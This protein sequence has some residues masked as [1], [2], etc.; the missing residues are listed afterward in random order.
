MIGAL[1]TVPS[2]RGNWTQFFL[3]KW[4]AQ[5]TCSCRSATN[6]VRGELAG[7]YVSIC[8]VPV[9]YQTIPYQWCV[10]RGCGRH[11]ST[12]VACLPLGATTHVDVTTDTA[13]LVDHH[14]Y[15]HTVIN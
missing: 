7:A 5:S 13:V 11:V 6:I 8:T 4:T 1:L 10:V 2:V 3:P 15:I 9:A 14:T 12:H